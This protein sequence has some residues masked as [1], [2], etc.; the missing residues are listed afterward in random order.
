MQEKEKQELLSQVKYIEDENQEVLVNEGVIKERCTEYFLKLFDECEK[1]IL[2]WDILAT[3]KK[4]EI[5]YSVNLLV[6]IK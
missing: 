2:C 1:Q 3:L 6:Q 5:A 4:I